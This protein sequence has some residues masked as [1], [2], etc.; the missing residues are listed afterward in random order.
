M[1][2]LMIGGAQRDLATRSDIEE[3]WINRQVGGRRA[4]GE[5]VCV[6]IRIMTGGMD[7]TL[8]SAGCGG[9]GGGRNLSAEE[10]RL[11]DLWVDRGL[12]RADF[13]GGSVVAF[14]HQLFRLIA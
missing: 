2:T 5:Q 9:G 10:R 1:V 7:L 14:L 12:S 13:T 8:A 11:V 6:R 4:D 3:S